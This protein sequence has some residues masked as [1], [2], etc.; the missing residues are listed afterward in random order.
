[1][2]V[3]SH[4]LHKGFEYGLRMRQLRIF[5]K[6]KR[7]SSDGGCSWLRESPKVTGQWI[8]YDWENVIAVS[9]LH[10]LYRPHW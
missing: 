5:I 2:V 4:Q 8:L 10:H 3:G 1:M 7:S 9:F 6:I